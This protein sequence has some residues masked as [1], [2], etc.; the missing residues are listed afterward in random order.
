MSWGQDQ[1]DKGGREEH[2][3]DCDV[4]IVAAEDSR[5]W[6]CM[7][8]A[9]AFRGTCREGCRVSMSGALEA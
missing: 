7:V 6:I 3:D 2:L 5:K 9:E 4:A 8:D 1:G